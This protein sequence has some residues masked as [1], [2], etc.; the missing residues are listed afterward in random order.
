MDSQNYLNELERMCK[1]YNEAGKELAKV[2]VEKSSAILILMASSKSA[3]EAE[4]RWQ[5][6]PSGNREIELIYRLRGLKELISANKM[7]IRTKNAE[8]YHS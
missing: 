2:L 5:A 1:D 3:K 7:Y 4:L 6:T 8:D